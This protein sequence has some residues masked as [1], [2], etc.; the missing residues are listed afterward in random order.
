M[1]RESS[2]K[3]QFV[4]GLLS[5][6]TGGFTQQ[7]LSPFAIALGAS[8]PQLALLSAVPNVFYAL[9]HLFTP[10]IAVIIGSRVRAITW[11]VIGHGAMVAA[12][13]AVVLL[14]EVVRVYTLIGITAVEVVFFGLASPIWAS[15]MS[16]T[17]DRTEYGRF[18]GRRNRIF[19]LISFASSCAAGVFLFLM[20]DA[21][22]G[23]ALLFLAA[24]VCRIAGGASLSRMNDLPLEHRQEQQFSYITFLRRLPKSNF[25]RFVL[26]VALFNLCLGLA[27]PF[28]NV[29]LL[30][31]L[32]FNYLLYMA[33][34]SLATIA[35]LV[36]LPVWGRIADRHGNAGVLK[37][38]LALLAVIPM[39][40]I[41]W[42]HPVWAVLMSA[43]AAYVS[44]GFGLLTMNFIYDATSPGVRTR[45]ISYFH[46]TNALFAAAGAALSGRLI[47]IIPPVVKG[48]AYLTMF[49]CCGAA[50]AI[51]VFAASRLFREVR[52][53]EPIDRIT[54]I[55]HVFGLTDIVAFGRQRLA[56]RHRSE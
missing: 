38:N 32:R 42:K 11:F 30:N 17:V 50:A 24:G 23:F 1:S 53:A 19:G 20:R 39:L 29:Y 34:V 4:E 47:G 43:L 48:S 10:R 26:G 21:L 6:V 27:A 18:F 31:E 36:S 7:Y 14:P 41:V 37:A 22:A 52:A 13:A 25:A 45:C 51:A 40:W 55:A 49:A 8:N 33:T 35:G 54:L 2:L 12:V 5:A 16:D 28:Y 9:V 46:L 44:G 56:G 3:A 15:L